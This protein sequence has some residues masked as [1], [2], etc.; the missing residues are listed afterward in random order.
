MTFDLVKVQE[1]KEERILAYS[2]DLSILAYYAG[3]GLCS[4]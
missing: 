1:L 3:L 4:T 2:Q